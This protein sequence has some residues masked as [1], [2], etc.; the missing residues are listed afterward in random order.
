MSTAW[1]V[2]LTQDTNEN[3]SDK[4][5]TVPANTEWELLW[6]WVEYD[7]TSTAGNRQLEIQI[8]D[9]GST[10]AQWQAGIIQPENISYNYLFGVGIPDLLTIRDGNYLTT[11]MMGGQFLTEGQTIRIWDNNAIDSSAD[12]MVVR[13]EYGY[14][15]I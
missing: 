9:S 10:I 3:D 11:P 5:F 2:A 13:I 4:S 8:I 1:R 6:I 15:E 14:H 12:D 7:S